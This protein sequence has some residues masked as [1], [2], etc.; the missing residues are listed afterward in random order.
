MHW[1]EGIRLQTVALTNIGQVTN[2]CLIQNKSLQ[3]TENLLLFCQASTKLK[4]NY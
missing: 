1:S 2:G 4:L 3:N